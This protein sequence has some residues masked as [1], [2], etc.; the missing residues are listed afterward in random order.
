MFTRAFRS[1]SV[2]KQIAFMAI[3]VAL[4]VAAN[5]VI[6][7]EIGPS[8]RITFSY[9]VCFFA[10]YLLGPL[11]GFLVGFL[12]DGIGFLIKPTGVYWFNG[13]TL[14]LFGFLSGLIMNGIR[15]DGRGWLYLKASIAF[16]VC[17]IVV[18]CVV[19]SITNYYYVYLFVWDG[20]Y[21][22]AFWAWL[23]GRLG[24]QSIVFAVNVVACF[25]VLPI[26]ARLKVFK[27]NG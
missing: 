6:E 14:G 20:V 25:L 11:P 22:K 23:A 27:D 19:N 9:F 26:S 4:A 2:A 16:L 7:I 1:M 15:K 12:G 21:K 8:N 10:G 3:F 13:I 24:I 18:T 17:F 5:S